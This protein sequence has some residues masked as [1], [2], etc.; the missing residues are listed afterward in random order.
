MEKQRRFEERYQKEL[1]EQYHN[2]EEGKK[3]GL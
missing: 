1:A 3:N 2:S